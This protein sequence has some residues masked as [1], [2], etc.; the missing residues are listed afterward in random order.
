MRAVACSDGALVGDRPARRPCPAAA[1]CSW[2]SPAAASAA[3]TCTRA[4]HADQVAGLM[5]ELDYDDFMR[6]DQEVVFGHEFCGQVVAQGPGCRGTRA[7][8]TPVVAVPLLRGPDG[9]HPTG[10][11][12]KAPGAYAEQVLVEESLAFPVPNGLAPD[13]AVLTEP[14]AVGWHAVRRERDRQARR[15]G[16]HRLRPDR[17]GGDLPAQGPRHRARD[18]Q[19]PL[20]RPPRPG[21]RLRRR[22]GG[23]PDAPSPRSPP[24]P[25]TGT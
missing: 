8:G 25:S 6:S 11:S 18:R 20:P 7:E 23:R 12:A 17:P 14:M 1:S 22:R 15:G 13:V 2:T 10:L 3:R 4:S 16:R 21:R 5:G 24:R 9:V 19:R